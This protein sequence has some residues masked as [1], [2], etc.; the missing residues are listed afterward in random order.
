MDISNSL[1]RVGHH[2]SA[3]IKGIKCALSCMGVC[4]D[5][6]AEPFHRFRAE[7]RARVH[8]QL[9]ELKAGVEKLLSNHQPA[10]GSRRSL[11]VQTGTH[12]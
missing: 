3:V 6:M 11:Q 1:Y 7:E 10:D 9:P 12:A 8:R 5:F 2:A 4:D